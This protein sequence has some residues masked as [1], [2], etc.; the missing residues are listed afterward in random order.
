[1]IALYGDQLCSFALQHFA[2]AERILHLR[3]KSDLDGEGNWHFGT[4]ER[5][6][7]PLDLVVVWEKERPVVA[8]PRDALRSQNR[9]W[10]T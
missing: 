4:A 9:R 7:D 1:M 6:R 3:E 5:L 8:L 10:R 2:Q